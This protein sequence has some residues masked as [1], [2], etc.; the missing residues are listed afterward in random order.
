MFYYLTRF[1]KKAVFLKKTA[2]THLWEDMTVLR[3][4]E[5]LATKIYN[6]FFVGIEILHIFHLII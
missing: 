6:L 3:G 5:R 2:K 1:S 4:R